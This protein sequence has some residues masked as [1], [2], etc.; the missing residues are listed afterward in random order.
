MAWFHLHRSGNHVCASS[1]PAESAANIDFSHRFWGIISALPPHATRHRFFAATN[2]SGA[3]PAVA[4]APNHWI[5]N[6]WRDLI[7]C[8]SARRSSFC[9][10]S[11]S[12][13]R[14]GAH[15]TFTFSSPPFGAMGHHLPGM[16]RAYGDRALFVTLS[17]ALHPCAALLLSDLCRLLLV[18]LKGIILVVFFGASGMG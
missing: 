18:G 8:T 4:V 3:V 1:Q 12:R 14:V 17:L 10:C 5:L 11:R 13:N 7:L 15:R 2:R 9:R 6:S 16:I